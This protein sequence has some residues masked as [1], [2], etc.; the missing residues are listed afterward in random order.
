[1]TG[2]VA[3]HCHGVYKKGGVGVLRSEIKYIPRSGERGGE[4]GS[5]WLPGE[6]RR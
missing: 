3:R 4:E 1:M 2:G 5:A 6:K